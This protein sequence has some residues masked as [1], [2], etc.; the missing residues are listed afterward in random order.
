M[1]SNTSTY[2]NSALPPSLGEDSVTEKKL[3]IYTD[4][5]YSPAALRIKKGETVIFKNQSSR[6]M[7][8]ASAIHPSHRSYPTTGGC[9]GSTFDACKGVQPDDSW[10]FTFDVSGSW[11]YHNHLNPGDAG[12]IEVK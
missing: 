11:K 9:L 2:S 7:W 8:T 3:V 12:T 10:L 5:G 4:A 6:S 1:D